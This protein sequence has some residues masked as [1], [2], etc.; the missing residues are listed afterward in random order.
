M[1]GVSNGEKEA[2]SEM[3]DDGRIVPEGLGKQTCGCRGG[4]R[5][6]IVLR[7]LCDEE[8][9]SP[10]AVNKCSKYDLYR[11]NFPLN[12]FRDRSLV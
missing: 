3:L 11:I 6:H 4:T 12:H 5:R 9:I 7:D 2:P 10:P 1:G 8:G